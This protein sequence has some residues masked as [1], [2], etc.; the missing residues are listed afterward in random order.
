MVGSG[1][2]PGIGITGRA[3]FGSAGVS[4]NGVIGLGTTGIGEIGTGVMGIGVIGA[5]GRICAAAVDVNHPANPTAAPISK[6]VLSRMNHAPLLA[7]RNRPAL[8]Q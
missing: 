4:G 5:I 1:A 7:C 6:K 8:L 2:G 3:G